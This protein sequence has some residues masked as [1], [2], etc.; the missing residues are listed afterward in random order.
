MPPGPAI[1]TQSIP[2]SQ[3]HQP[4]LHQVQA[5]FTG[6][7]PG[8]GQRSSVYPQPG[9]PRE[10]PKPQVMNLL[11]SPF[12]VALPVI[13]ETSN[14]PAP[15]IPPNPE[16]DALLHS[17]SQ[18]L[19]QQL[20]N[21]VAQNTAALP[22]LQ[23]QQ[24]ALGSAL[25]TLES[26]IA[27]ITN[28]NRTLKSNVNI[29]QNSIRQADGAISD[30]QARAAKG[31]IPAVDDMLV[32]PTVVGKQ[33]YDVVCEERGIEAALW[34]LQ[35]ALVRGRIS[36]DIWAKRTR[37]LSRELFAKKALERKIGRGLGLTE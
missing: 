17:L 20:H 4:F 18:A 36:T 7:I 31:D 33:L 25:S 2:Q 37:E 21:S 27:N 22:P 15:P 1:P 29:L 19:T 16:K 26:E 6:V 35:A 30:A 28:L 9:P 13:G 24:H 11:D 3:L 5:P 12:D 8:L 10:Q 23:A 34:A 14:I 32:A